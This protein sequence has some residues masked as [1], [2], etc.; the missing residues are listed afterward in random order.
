MHNLE[1]LMLDMDDLEILSSMSNVENGIRTGQKW[2]K[3]LH[4]YENCS[5]TVKGIQ[6]Y[7]NCLKNIKTG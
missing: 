4:K 3:L 2:S 5:I 6:M 1:I 7:H